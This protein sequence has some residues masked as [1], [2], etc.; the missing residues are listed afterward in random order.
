MNKLSIYPFNKKIKDAFSLFRE[1]MTKERAVIIFLF[2]LSILV[3][4]IYF[5]HT[6][7]FT[8]T[9]DAPGHFEYIEFIAEKMSLPAA[10]ELEQSYHPPLYYFISAVFRKLF[11]LFNLKDDIMNRA[12]QF[13]S[14][15]FHTGFLIAGTLIIKRYIS[16]KAIL[17]LCI[18]AFYFWPSSILHSAR[19]GND[20]LFYCFYSFSLLFLCK[21]FDEERTTDISLFTLFTLLCIFTKVN[22]IVILGCSGILVLVK[23]FRTK[24]KKKFVTRLIPFIVL[25]F[26]GFIGIFAFPVIDTLNGYKV[27]TFAN[28][29]SLMGWGDFIG[30]EAKNYLYFD[31]NIFMNQ[32]FT[33]LIE[34]WGGRQYFWN[35]LLKTSLFGEFAAEGTFFRNCATIM[36]FLLLWIIFIMVIGIMTAKLDDAKRK[37]PILLNLFLFLLSSAIYRLLSPIPCSNDFRYI[38]PVIIAV[39]VILGS[40]LS[41][42]NEKKLV[43]AGYSVYGIVV[44]FIVFSIIFYICWL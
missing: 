12:L 8:R 6:D 38:L 33:D 30:V 32:P 19:I 42:F 24:E 22:G 41:F 31:L 40:T 27:V 21:W 15:C 17:F 28:R 3:R 43:I 14:F 39:P 16:N 23:F 35:Y 10:N 34:D 2:V 9:D 11:S 25:L 20:N 13:L 44:V 7:P 4:I 18:A 26:L 37:L 29:A 36:S 1:F 5:S